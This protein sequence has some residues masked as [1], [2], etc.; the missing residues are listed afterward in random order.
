MRKVYLDYNATTPIAPSVFEAMKPYFIEHFGNPS[1]EHVWGKAA[2]FAVDEA[3]ERVANSIGAEAHEIIFTASGTEA[4]NLAILGTVLRHAPDHGAH[5]LISA[6]EHPAVVQPALEL[7]RRGYRVSI[8]PCDEQGVV[9]P[10][11]V[12]E[13]IEDRTV[14]VSVMHANNETGAI[15]PVSELASLCRSRG[16]LFHTDA[17]QTFGK[18][19]TNVAAVGADLMTLVG[20]KFYAPKGIGAL[21]VRR[22]TPIQSILFGAGHEFGLRPGTENVPYIVGLGKASE[23]AGKALDENQHRLASLCTR[24]LE[25]LQG[26]IDDLVVHAAGAPRIPNTLLIAFPEVNG[27]ELLARASEILCLH[28][29]S[30]S[31]WPR[32]RLA[33]APRHGCLGGGGGRHH[34]PLLRLADFAGRG[35]VRR[36][37]LD[38]R[39]GV[40]DNVTQHL[41]S[42]SR[43]LAA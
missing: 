3:R 6:I 5:L 40:A 41:P 36:R 13:L 2:Y 14:L 12:R 42:S 10:D 28:R 32:V 17:A 39:L 35:R 8:C 15:Q 26:R 27:R 33:H 31:Q 7:Q 37:T 21:Y 25:L 34:P 20:H 16:I 18:I 24:L 1:S 38:Q 23:L 43:W 11:T 29:I 22:T 19:N 4:N 9:S 30:V